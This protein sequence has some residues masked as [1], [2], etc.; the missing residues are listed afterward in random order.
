MHIEAPGTVR[1]WLDGELKQSGSAS[2]DITERLHRGKHTL[3]LAVAAKSGGPLTARLAAED[4][5]PVALTTDPRRTL[6][7]F[8]NV[9]L[10]DAL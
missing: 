5:S 10:F 6:A 3:L 9:T 1:L 2:L 4:G 7:E 8:K